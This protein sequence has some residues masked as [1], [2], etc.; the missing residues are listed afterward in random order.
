MDVLSAHESKCIRFFSVAPKYHFMNLITNRD[1][2]A[3]TTGAGWCIGF[4]IVLIDFV[5]MYLERRA[6][7]IA[8]CAILSS[9]LVVSLSL[10]LCPLYYSVTFSAVLCYVLDFST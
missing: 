5:C 4:L 9:F 10:F 8:S 1:K 3:N 6:L 7:I 2:V